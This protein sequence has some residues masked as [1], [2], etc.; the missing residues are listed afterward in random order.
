MTVDETIEFLADQRGRRYVEVALGLP[1]GDD[2]A[3]L[4]ALDGQLGDVKQ[5][6]D[7]WS[8]RVCHPEVPPHIVSGFRIRRELFEK[9]DVIAVVP[10]DPEERGEQGS[11]WILTILQ[12]GVISEVTVYV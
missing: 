7:R 10:E 1:A 11:I 3:S 8:I 12:G 4:A 9:A 6:N 5:L 2:M